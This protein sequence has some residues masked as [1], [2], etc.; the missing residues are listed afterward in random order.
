MKKLLILSVFLCSYISA[1]AQNNSYYDRMEHVFGNIDKTK[2]ST[3]FLKEFGVRFNEVEAY[4]GILQNN[5]WVD[6]TQWQSL[7]SSLYTMRVG[8]VAQ[9]MTPPNIVFD[10]L[11]NQQLGVPDVLLVAQHYTYQQYK[12]NAYTNGDVNISN[13]RIY[14][15]TG[16]NPY[17]FKTTFAVTPLR[18]EL[19]GNTFSFKL[20]NSL[21]YTNTSSTLNQV[22]IDFGNGQGYQ[23]VSINSAK[24]VTYNSGGEKVLKAKFVYNGGPT[25]YS[26]SKIWIDY[27]APKSK[28]QA[29]FNG[30]RASNHIITGVPWQGSSAT[31]V[32]TVELAPGNTQ[33]TKPLI[34]VEGFDPDNSFNYTNFIYNENNGGINIDIDPTTV[35]YSLNQAIEDEGYDLVFVNFDN[36]TD[37]IQRNAYLVE[38]V[39]A[40]VNSQKAVAGSTEKNVVLGMS[41]GGLVAKYALRHM[42][43][44]GNPNTNHDTQLFIS[45]DAPHQGAN[46]PV[47]FQAMLRHLVGEEISLPVFFSLIDINIVDFVDFLPKLEDGLALLQTPAAQ[48]MLIYQLQ[49]IGDNISIDNTT[50]HHSFLNEYSSMGYPQEDNIRNIAIASGSECGTSLSYNPYSNL[51]DVNMKIDLP[52]LITNIVFAFINGISINPIRSITSV[53]STNTDIIAQFNAKALPNQQSKKIYNGKIVIKKKILFLINVE[54]PLIDEEN[55]YSTATMLPLDNASGG[56][57]DLETFVNLPSGMDI[58]ILERKFNFIP[59]FSSLDLGGGNEPIIYSDLNHAY[60]PLSPPLSPKNTPFDNFYT[61]PIS[62][63]NHIQFTLN[64]GNW[65]MDELRGN[66]AFY[67]CI[68]TCTTTIPIEIDGG[69]LKLCD[70]ATTTYTLLNLNPDSNVIVNWSV[71]PST[72]I[73]SLVANGNAVTITS[74]GNINGTATLKASISTNCGNLDIEK[75][76]WLGEPHVSYSLENIP[77]GVSYQL[78][79][80]PEEIG[81]ENMGVNNANCIDQIHNGGHIGACMSGNAFGYTNN[82]YVEREVQVDNGCGQHT[83]NIVFGSGFQVEYDLVSDSQSPNTFIL[84]ESAPNNVSSNTSFSQVSA[85][86]VILIQVFNISGNLILE[87]NNNYF[88]LSQYPAGNYYAKVFINNELVLQKNLIN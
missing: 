65:L 58:Y 56:I 55:L 46:V 86:E 72:A 39:I 73:S 14:D 23:N 31:G 60:S 76:L 63:E 79:S 20:P 51:V 44:D 41:M 67:T 21:I 24:N 69:L 78:V 3:G 13:D 27:V 88:S 38:A 2:V 68:S 30:S 87:T 82:W 42:E 29:R 12:A 54:E 34:V 37:Y 61:N 15:V 43:I 8:T 66:N 16:R 59:T 1:F 81:L 47:A 6:K 53:L 26:H 36:A 17:E 32:I 70:N 4:N 28:K 5:N 40:W 22:Q 48:Q 80:F 7:Y 84:V 18:Q 52:Y 57:Y 74:S 45:H 33:L 9:H 10:N 49:G 77:N 50:L 71:I 62:S 83:F 85:N 11:K 64:N 75:T 35:F 19:R 25:L